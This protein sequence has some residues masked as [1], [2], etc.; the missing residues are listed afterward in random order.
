MGT[1]NCNYHFEKCEN[2]TLHSMF[3][4]K[5]SWRKVLNFKFSDQGYLATK[6]FLSVGKRIGNK[7]L[8]HKIQ[9]IRICV[10]HE[11]LKSLWLFVNNKDRL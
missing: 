5:L 7:H 10:D 4:L 1:N 2:L 6:K 3:K 11:L 9:V 8:E